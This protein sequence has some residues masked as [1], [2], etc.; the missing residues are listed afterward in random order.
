MRDQITSVFAAA[1]PATKT[2]YPSSLLVERVYG[3]V[4]REG[5]PTDALWLARA[6]VAALGALSESGHHR[7][8]TPSRPVAVWTRRPVSA[9]T[10]PP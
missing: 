2:T 6:G 8:S 3:K 5:S 10:P 9:P 4:L 7:R 1:K